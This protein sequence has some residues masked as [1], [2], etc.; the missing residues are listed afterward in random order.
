MSAEKQEI[1]T[2]GGAHRFVGL[3]ENLEYYAGT[4]SGAEP[5]NVRGDNRGYGLVFFQRE[6]YHLTTV[7]SSGLRF[8]PIG[9]EPAQELACTVYREQ[10]E[11]ARY[12]VDL[13][14]Q[15]L[16]NMGTHVVPDQVIPNEEPL[17]ANTEFH[18]VLTSGHPLFPAEFTRFTDADGVEQLQVFTLLPVTLGEINF[19]LD[20]GVSALRQQWSRFEVDVF[21][22][23][24]PS[25]A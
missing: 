23:G 11:A 13:T 18:G 10:A 7:I 3:A 20:S 16:V 14:A 24:R 5:P 15:L 8:Q 6:E 25:V 19:A 1:A 21:D 22:L 12:L 4:P 2:G 17:L 9:A